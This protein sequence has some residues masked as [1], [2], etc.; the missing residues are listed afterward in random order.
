MTFEGGENF[1]ENSNYIPSALLNKSGVGLDTDDK[2][3]D[4]R[5][6]RIFEPR[7]FSQAMTAWW[8]NTFEV[9]FLMILYVLAWFYPHFISL[10]VVLTSSNMVLPINMVNVSRINW[11]RIFNAI[12]CVIIGCAIYYKLSRKKDYEFV[13]KEEAEENYDWFKSMGFTFNYNDG[14]REDKTTNSYKFKL[15][16]EENSLNFEY[17]ALAISLLAFS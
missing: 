8:Q 9:T 13:K 2:N 15:M 12:N 14:P 1:I 3:F 17:G 11:G 16:P 4:V 10:T 5:S 6:A 7:N